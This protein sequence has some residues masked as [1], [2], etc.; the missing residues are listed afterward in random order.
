MSTFTGKIGT[1]EG[2]NR[3]EQP[4]LERAVSM[5]MA[6]LLHLSGS[7]PRAVEMSAPSSDSTG[8]CWITPLL[9]SA[10]RMI[11]GLRAFPEPVIQQNR[12]HLDACAVLTFF[13]LGNR[14]R[15]G[16]SRR[17]KALALQTRS[18]RRGQVPR[19][20]RIRHP[21]AVDPTECQNPPHWRGNMN[22]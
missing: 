9:E 8:F 22:A 20:S 18:G 13:G 4:A 14:L 21:R 1:G 11:P 16:E 2:Q 7:V 17:F 12:T 3:E 10:R 19:L 6:E 5:G 15:H